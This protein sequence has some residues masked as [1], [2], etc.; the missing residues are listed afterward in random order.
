MRASISTA[1]FVLGLMVSAL[2]AD[3]PHARLP[4]AAAGWKIELVSQ[5][6]D[7]SFPT[8]IVAASDGTLYVGSD[9]MDMPGPATE[10][11]D[12]VLAIKSGKSTVF[13]ENLWC[14]MGLEWADDTLFVVHAPFLSALKDT[15][16]DGKADTR[17][18]LMTGLGPK[19]PGSNGLN[20]HI[21]AGIRLGIDG[22]LYIAVGDKGIPHGVGKDGRSIQLFGGGVIRIRPDGTGLEV[23]STGECNPRGLALSATDEIF[24][25]GTG[26][27]SKKWPSSLTHHIVGGHFGYPYQFLTSPYRALPVLAGFAGGAG[28]QGV[29]YNED[30]LGAEFRGNLFLCDWGN[31]SVSRLELRKAGGTFAVSRRSTLVS[32]GDCPSFHPF[33]LAVCDDA[34]SFWL[35]DWAFD[36]YLDAGGPT[37]RLFRLSAVESHRTAPAPR[38]VGQ[39]IAARIKALDHPALSVRMQSQRILIGA[40]A[41]ALEPLI[42]RFNTGE[43]E[44]GRLHALWALDAIGGPLAR[45]AIAA[46][47]ADPS[48]KVRLQ[49]ARSAG[50]SR[51]KSV[52]AKLV[53]GLADR[54]PAVRREAAIAL[55]RL[56]DSAA[57]SALYKAL[58]DSDAFAAWSVRHAIRALQAWD[59]TALVH[60]LLDER[61]LEPALRLTDESWSTTV[62]AALTEALSQTASAP[63]RG[64]IVANLAGLLHKYPDWNGTWFGTNPL[65][66]AFPRKTKDW[67]PQ[68][69][70]AVLDGLS[71]GLTDRESAV[72]FQAITALAEA[73]KDAPPRLRSALPLET[74]PTN[75]AVLIET[76]G[77][78]KDGVSLPLFVEILQ[79]ADRGEAV[80]MA[81]LVALTAFRDPQ[82]LRARLALLYAEKT[83]PALVARALPD[84]ARLGFLPPNDLGSFM[85]NASPEVRASALLSLNV[86]KTL[87]ADLKQSVIDHMA[88]PD[89]SVRQAAILA[90]VPLQLHAAV[91]RLLELAAK[92]TATDY[93][94][95]VEALCGLRDPRAVSVYLSA[96][97]DTNPRLRKLA[98]SALL[99]IRDKARESLIAASRSDRIS[100]SAAQVLDRVLARFT[101]IASWNV[102]GPFPRVT[103]RLF[104]GDRSIDFGKT[105]I[106]ATGRQLAWTTRRG[107]A[108]SGRVDLD[109]L[110]PR[111]QG[112]DSS[113]P[114]ESTSASLG[115]FGYAEVNALRA[116]P[117]LLL[118][119][120]TG[121]LMITLN[122]EKVCELA[123]A[124][125]HSEISDPEVVRC[126][127]SA[128]RNRILV[129]T[130]QSPGKWSYAIQIAQLPAAKRDPQA[131]VTSSQK[132]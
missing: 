47:I 121:A 9:P 40:G 78:L 63:V 49:A 21:A 80:R 102:I 93:A 5:A 66:G 104:I 10:P 23:V 90:L 53:Q 12:R 29:C 132:Q 114:P 96:L 128:G 3:E 33:S 35:V 72:R 22:F 31:Q 54:D 41:A 84:L 71:L 8:A 119:S 76:L 52:T 46:A 105:T 42:A 30:G 59:K 32:K 123:G 115:A 110:I 56:N 24:T 14:V 98:E 89:E 108:A 103:P 112:P 88:D 28:A 58:G 37:G 74:D 106:G 120:S 11:I 79:D 18:D 82:S 65:A 81:A 26:D 75:Q 127:L 124:A 1:L 83:P 101:P 50:I 57:A 77:N 43:P 118:A 19:L 131:A 97:D 113:A 126:N 86:K 70:K 2:R 7:V 4:A 69:M 51:D 73:G 109:D 94:T 15:D 38:P 122:E 25:F 87:P 62:I 17:V 13:A 16:A 95:A 48:A 44:T 55:G 60:A 36:G 6:P 27:D 91:P 99:A 20:D 68:A 125:T 107:D 111:G 39:D 61:R 34:A 85:E 117:A 129:F 130:R 45:K 67:D 100:S 116:G 64:R 92:P